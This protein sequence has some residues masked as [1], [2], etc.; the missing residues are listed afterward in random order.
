[1]EEKIEKSIEYL[2]D[3]IRKSAN[4]DETMKFAQAILNLANARA[5]L[6]NSKKG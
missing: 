3:I 4:A 6:L 2:A 5:A 1:M